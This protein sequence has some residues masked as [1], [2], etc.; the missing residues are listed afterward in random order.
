[1]LAKLKGSL[2]RRESTFAKSQDSV[3]TPEPFV[4]LGSP[5]LTPPSAHPPLSLVAAITSPCWKFHAILSQS[6]WQELGSRGGLAQ[7]PPAGFTASQWGGLQPDPRAHHPGLAAASPTPLCR[8]QQSFSLVLL[9]I[10]PETGLRIRHHLS[11]AIPFQHYQ[12]NERRGVCI[13]PVPA[14]ALVAHSSSM[15]TG[16]G[17]DPSCGQHCAE[18]RPSII[19]LPPTQI[20]DPAASHISSSLGCCQPDRGGK[21][22]TEKAAQ[23]KGGLKRKKEGKKKRKK[24]K[25]EKGKKKK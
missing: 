12:Q 25:K 24:K 7:H 16:L 22:K 10:A 23:E 1:M 13:C 11:F 19:S 6:A 4:S 3:S 15:L 2:Q 17:P 9:H 8:V 20:R 21:R 14:Q 18:L 5:Q